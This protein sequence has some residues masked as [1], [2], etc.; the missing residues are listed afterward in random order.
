[1]VRGGSFLVSLD[2]TLPE[3]SILELVV[4]SATR[5][6]RS[7]YR[8]LSFSLSPMFHF[9]SRVCVHVFCSHRPTVDRFVRFLL[10]LLTAL[11]RTVIL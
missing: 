1:M 8:C 4:R 10:F 7:H 5:P 3:H 11:L 9:C 2:N 6:T